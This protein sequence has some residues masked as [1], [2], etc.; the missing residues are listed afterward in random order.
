[1]RKLNN[2]IIFLMKKYGGKMSCNLGDIKFLF[3]RIFLYF[4]E[5]FY[6]R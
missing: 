1:M 5:N 4:K 2:L 6:I 3:L